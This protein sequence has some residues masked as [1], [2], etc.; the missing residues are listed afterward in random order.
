MRKSIIFFKVLERTRLMIDHGIE[1][2]V[3]LLG[4]TRVQNGDKECYFNENI[5]QAV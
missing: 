5:K 4:G 2:P 1:K 3:K